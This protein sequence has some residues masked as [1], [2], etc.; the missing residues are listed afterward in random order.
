MKRE[1]YTKQKRMSLSKIKAVNRREAGKI[2]RK[3]G[4][5]YV[6]SCGDHDIYKHKNYEEIV[7]IPQDV[8]FIMWQKYVKKFNLLNI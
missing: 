3:N 7:S 5:T 6:R 8:N 2:L 4:W 1:Q